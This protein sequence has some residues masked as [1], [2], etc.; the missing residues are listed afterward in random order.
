MISRLNLRQILLAFLSAPLLCQAND[1]DYNAANEYN[2]YND[3]NDAND[4]NN[5]Y[6]YYN[7][8][9]YDASD[10]GNF[11]LENGDDT[12]TYWTHFYIQPQRCVIF[13]NKDVIVF[14]VFGNGDQCM[15]TPL[16]TFYATV[17][18][19]MKGW[20]DEIEQKMQDTGVDD[21]VA[22]EAA[23][24]QYCTPK[25]VN[26]EVFYLMLGCADDTTQSIAVNVYSDDQCKKKLTYGDTDDARIDISDIQ[27]RETMQKFSAILS[28][29]ANTDQ[30]FVCP[31]P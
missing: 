2:A 1:A 16:G 11:N 17:P 3:Y 31:S 27:V 6:E 29:C 21:Y 14:E 10:Y 30:C 19:Y 20:T 8:Q 28:C 4:E 5:Q 22:P 15:K 25:E 23:N 7:Y 18:D 26:G 9:E 13:K 12:I 24:Y